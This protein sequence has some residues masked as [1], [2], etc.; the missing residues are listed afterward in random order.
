MEGKKGRKYRNSEKR[1][2]WRGK[3]RRQRQKS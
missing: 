2:R 3:R 1:G